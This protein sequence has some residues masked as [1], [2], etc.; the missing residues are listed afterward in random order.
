MADK[1]NILQMVLKIQSINDNGGWWDMALN[2]DSIMPGLHVAVFRCPIL[3]QSL[4]R[5]N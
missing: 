5:A 1:C 3:V 2:R 4:I